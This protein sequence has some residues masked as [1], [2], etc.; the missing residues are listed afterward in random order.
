MKDKNFKNDNEQI[1]NETFQTEDL[2]SK[3][4]NKILC[5]KLVICAGAL[6]IANGVLSAD[7]PFFYAGIIVGTAAFTALQCS[8]IE[9]EQLSNSNEKALLKTKYHNK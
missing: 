2:I 8:Q 5:E 7:L 1:N 9:M 4:K 3:T 6:S